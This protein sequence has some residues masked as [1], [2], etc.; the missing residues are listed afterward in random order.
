MESGAP[1]PNTRR[2]ERRERASDRQVL[3]NLP[4]DVEDET[5]AM[6]E[7]FRRAD[8]QRSK[9]DTETVE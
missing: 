6:A 3:S 9:E 7:A 8:R 5:T 1:A 2:Y 4:K